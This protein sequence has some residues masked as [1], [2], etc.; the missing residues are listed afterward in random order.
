MPSSWLPQDGLLFCITHTQSKVLILDPERADVLE[1]VVKELSKSGVNVIMVLESKTKTWAGMSN[2]IAVLDGYKGDTDSILKDPID[3]LPEDNATI[4]FTSGTTGRPSEWLGTS[5][6][7]WLLAPD[8][9][10]PCVAE[11]TLSRLNQDRKKA[12]LLQFLSSTPPERQAIRFVF[13]KYHIRSSLRA[14]SLD[15]RCSSWAQ[16]CSHVELEST[17]GLIKAEYIVMAGGLPPNTLPRVP[18]M[19]ADLM[20]IG[21][22]SLET[23]TFGGAPASKMLP[24]KVKSVI[25]EANVSQGYGAT[26]T[27]SVAVSL[28][29]EDQLLRPTSCGL[30]TL[31]NDLI[32]VD[33]NS[34]VVLP[35]GQVGEVWIRGPNVMQGY[36]RD[37]EATKK[38]ITQDGWFRTGDLGYLDEEGF[39]YIK[40]RLKDIIIRGGENIVGQSLTLPKSSHLTCLQDS[41][42]VENAL[43]EEPGVQEAAAV[44]VPHEKLGEVVAAVVSVRPNAA[45]RITEESL[46]NLARKRLPR[47]AVPVI[48]VVLQQ[49]LEHTP[50][51][52][53]K[54]GPLREL[55]RTEWEKKQKTN[56]TSK[57]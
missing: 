9:E 57:L 3:I 2:W 47:F 37:P 33:P 14:R 22:F 56:A 20:E 24:A 7:L 12:F 19:V 15:D 21:G 8:F 1:P 42:S 26:E 51:G 44:G 30:P 35:T 41:V 45:S 49:E 17:G 39:L 32:V 16:D 36:W 34:L 27:N 6:M 5:V 25:A 54:K 50:S 46:I 40:D 31:V 13:D 52:K 53:V 43:Y 23:A 29:G 4:Y 38:A 18:S 48:V 55:A 28:A 10:L 11:K